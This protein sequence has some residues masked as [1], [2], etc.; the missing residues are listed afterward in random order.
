MNDEHCHGEIQLRGEK[1][2]MRV[3]LSP[4]LSPVTSTPRE[5]SR[6]RRAGVSKTT[7]TVVGWKKGNTLV[8]LSTQRRSHK[9]GIPRVKLL[10]VNSFPVSNLGSFLDH[11]IEDLACPILFV[12]KDLL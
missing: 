3:L 8:S 4:Y 2:R 12:C 7:A 9:F 11:K 6:T 5:K 1:L 10:P